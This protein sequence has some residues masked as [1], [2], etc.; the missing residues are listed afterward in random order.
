MALPVVST[1]HSGIPEALEDEVDGV[2]VPPADHVALADALARLLDD[3]GLRQRLGEQAREKV[4][5]HF[6]AERNGRR[7][8]YEFAGCAQSIPQTQGTAHRRGDGEVQT[9]EE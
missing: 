9:Y 8:L 2:L 6:D 5:T 1:R 3:P 7:L 4:V